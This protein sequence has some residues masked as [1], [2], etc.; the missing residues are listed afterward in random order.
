MA[1]DLVFLLKRLVTCAGPLFEACLVSFRDYCYASIFLVSSSWMFE[2]NPLF[3]FSSL[4]WYRLLWFV[5][6]WTSLASQGSLFF[7]FSF[8]FFSAGQR[9]LVSD[10]F[11]PCSLWTGNSVV[12]LL[13]SCLVCSKSVQ[14]YAEDCSLV[15][16]QCPRLVSTRTMEEHISFLCRSCHASSCTVLQILLFC[17]HSC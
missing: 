14:K 7:M 13:F 11:L 6:L 1:C 4:I 9:N 16:L 17:T 12:S 2:P 10:F 3:H 15:V 8:C 5:V